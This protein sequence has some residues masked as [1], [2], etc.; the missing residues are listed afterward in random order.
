MNCRVFTRFHRNLRPNDRKMFKAMLPLARIV[1]LLAVTSS[2]LATTAD[3][4][5]V[6]CGIML[7]KITVPG[8]NGKLSTLSLNTSGSTNSIRI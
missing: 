2:I 5:S 7:P 3:Y 8:F 4:A 6:S 1:M